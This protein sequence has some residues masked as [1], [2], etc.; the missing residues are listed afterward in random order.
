MAAKTPTMKPSSS[1]KEAKYW[2]ARRSTEPQ[3]P[4]STS[5]EVRVVSRIRAMDRPSTPR[6]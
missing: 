4:T 6:W 3:A 1:R 5:T 2:C